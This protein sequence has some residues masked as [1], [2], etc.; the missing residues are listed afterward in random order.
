MAFG[1]VV[2]MRRLRNI[3]SPM[4]IVLT[5]PSTIRSPVITDESDSQLDCEGGGEGLLLLPLPLPFAVVVGFPVVV[6]GV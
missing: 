5:V 2:G 3:T 1:I 6:L 4:R